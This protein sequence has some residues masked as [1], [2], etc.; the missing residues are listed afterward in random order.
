MSP[1]AVVG[2][3]PGALD[4][5]IGW[6]LPIAA[7]GHLPASWRKLKFGRLA[8][9]GVLGGGASQLLGCVPECVTMFSLV[10]V[11]HVAF[12]SCGRAPW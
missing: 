12:G 1:L 11:P 4:G 7:W 8:A 9:G 3:L 10:R 2:T 5:N 6:C